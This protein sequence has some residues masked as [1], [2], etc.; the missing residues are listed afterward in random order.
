M[1]GPT[2]QA[3]SAILQSKEK[4]QTIRLSEVNFRF[5]E[6]VFP[7]MPFVKM[8]KIAEEL[9]FVAKDVSDKRVKELE[10]HAVN[11]EKCMIEA[12]LTALDEG[13]TPH[14]FDYFHKQISDPG[15]YIRASRTDN[16]FSYH[17]GN[18]GWTGGQTMIPLSE[19]VDYIARN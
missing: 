11:P 9:G 18:H 5:F 12:V 7:H 13:L 17:K 16:S 14:F 4:Y 1:L 15:A 2:V 6:R 8:T 10:L 3:F 19:L